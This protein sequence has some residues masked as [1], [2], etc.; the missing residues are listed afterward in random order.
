[1]ITQWP[2]DRKTEHPCP[3]CGFKLAKV[4][5]SNMLVCHNPLCDLDPLF[6]VPNLEET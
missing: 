3:K 6:L 5:P 1:M 4:W 2:S